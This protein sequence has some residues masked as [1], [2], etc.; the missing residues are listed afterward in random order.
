MLDAKV[1][2]AAPA[3]PAERYAGSY[4]GGRSVTIDGGTLSYQRAGGPKVALIALGGN[5]FGINEDPM[6]R[7][8]FNTNGSSVT[9]LKLVRG[10]GST[11][12]A[13]RAQ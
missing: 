1:N 12:D 9:A 4:D 3:L 2:P 10:D 7:I 8:S 6:T 13:P 5:E 11:V